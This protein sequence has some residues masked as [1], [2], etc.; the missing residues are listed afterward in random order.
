MTP[1]QID[2]FCATLPAATRTVQ[3]EGVIV[4]KV[5]GKMCR[6]CIVRYCPPR[7]AIGRYGR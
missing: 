4:F 3:W 5:G 7:V 2:R 6:Y 1:K